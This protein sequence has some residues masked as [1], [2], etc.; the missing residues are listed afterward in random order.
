[1]KSLYFYCFF[2][3]TS[4]LVSC[5]VQNPEPVIPSE[6]IFTGNNWIIKLD[7]NSRTFVQ[8]SNLN[9]AEVVFS[10]KVKLKI[11]KAEIRFK[12]YLGGQTLDF[13]PLNYR[14]ADSTILGT[15]SLAGGGYYPEVRLYDSANNIVADSLVLKRFCVGEVFAIIGIRWRKVKFLM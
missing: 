1:M 11:S 13:V 2:I 3:C 7:S 10:A 4:F 15:Y 9:S 14:Q 12:N 5:K 6:A 8:R